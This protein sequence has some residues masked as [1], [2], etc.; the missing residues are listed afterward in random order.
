MDP[1]NEK[2]REAVMDAGT[3][4]ADS[5]KQVVDLAAKAS[6]IHYQGK[7]TFTA[8]DLRLVVNQ[9]TRIIW[10]ICKGSHDEVARA[11]EEAIDRKLRLP[12]DGTAGTELTPDQD[13]IDMDASVPRLEHE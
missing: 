1:T 8:M 9:L 2:L 4:M 6:S 5:M 11:I 13:V 10:G 7:Q 3:L 12:T